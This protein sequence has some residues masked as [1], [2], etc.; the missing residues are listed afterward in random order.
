MN[1]AISIGGSVPNLSALSIAAIIFLISDSG[2]SARNNACLLSV[3]IC[4]ADSE[5][6]CPAII[7]KTGNGPSK[8]DLARRK[9][10]R[11]L[12]VQTDICDGFRRRN[13][14]SESDLVWLSFNGETLRIDGS[15]A[16]V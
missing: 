2:C 4:S 14:A 1:P 6:R 13:S 10:S 8:D 12:D 7:P 3:A 15:G 11:L 5:I 16:T 9:T